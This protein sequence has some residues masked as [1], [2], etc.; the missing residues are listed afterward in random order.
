MS[1]LCEETVT[2]VQVWH[3]GITVLCSDISLGE[4]V[5]AIHATGVISGSIA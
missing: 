3:H 1:V 5:D 2:R 4:G